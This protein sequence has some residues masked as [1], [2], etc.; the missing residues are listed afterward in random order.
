MC[1]IE[2]HFLYRPN[3]PVYSRV[4]LTEE[5]LWH[6]LHRPSRMV[7]SLLM[8]GDRI[9]FHADLQFEITPNAASST[10]Y[11]RLLGGGVNVYRGRR[12]LLL[13]L[14]FIDATWSKNSAYGVI[15]RRWLSNMAV[16]AP[17]SGYISSS[18]H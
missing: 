12:R 16:C 2:P 14:Y 1:I 15:F 10:T 13:A 6:Y 9:L 17:T 4:T 3:Y 7:H 11:E 18:V 8:A 5:Q